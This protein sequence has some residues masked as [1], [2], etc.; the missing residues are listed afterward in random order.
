MVS[1]AITSFWTR[2]ARHRL[3]LMTKI[4]A[5]D[6]DTTNYCNGANTIICRH[7]RRTNT[8]QALT[9]HFFFVI[10]CWPKGGRVLLHYCASLRQYDN[11]DSFSALGSF[12]FHGSFCSTALKAKNH[13]IDVPAPKRWWQPLATIVSQQGVIDHCR[14]S[15][16]YCVPVSF[17]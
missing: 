15:R 16:V 10:P 2:E 9:M 12:A 8:T 17:G 1:Q 14:Y 6:K 4:R 5:S 7:A 11:N 3:I 13:G